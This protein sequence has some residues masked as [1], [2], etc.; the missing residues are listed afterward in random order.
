MRGR[1][2]TTVSEESYPQNSSRLKMDKEI[3]KSSVVLKNLILQI[4]KFLGIERN[5]EKIEAVIVVKDI[6]L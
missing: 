2:R 6:E 1:L 5:I 3:N 4:F